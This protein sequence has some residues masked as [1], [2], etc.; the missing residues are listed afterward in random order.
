MFGLFKKKQKTVG[1]IRSELKALYDLRDPYE[2]RFYN[3]NGNQLH[4]DGTYMRMPTFSANPTLGIKTVVELC[5]K[6]EKKFGRQHGALA[7][8]VWDNHTQDIVGGG[9]HYSSI[10]A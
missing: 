4:T 1:E 5:S 9:K 7:V 10:R 2:F 3:D 6:V 8:K